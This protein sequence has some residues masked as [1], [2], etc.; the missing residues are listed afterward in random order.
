MK[1][2]RNYYLPQEIE[3]WYIIPAIR[4]E[5]ASFLT[6]KHDITYEKAGEI[7]GVSKSAI[8][9]YLSDKRASKITIPNKI[10][11]KIKKSAENIAKDNKNALKEIEKILKLFRNSGCEC[12][13]CCKYNKGIIKMCGKKPIRRE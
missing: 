2:K 1:G 6:K 8:S 9:Q 5:L 12:D 10:K 7:L 3:V 13:I 11:K 4:K